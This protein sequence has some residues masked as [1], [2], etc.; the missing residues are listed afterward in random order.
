MD[1]FNSIEMQGG[2]FNEPFKLDFFSNNNQNREKEQKNGRVIL[3][4][5]EN[6][7]GKTSIAEALNNQDTENS[8]YKVNYYLDD[9]KLSNYNIPK[10]NTYVYDEEFI[11]T[12]VKYSEKDQKAKNLKA[13]V[14][15]GEQVDVDKEIDDLSREESELSNNINHEQEK[16]NNLRKEI[17]ETFDLLK[18][19]L[20]IDGG[21]ADLER[22][23]R[24]GAKKASVTKS[25]INEIFSVTQNVK[26]IETLKKEFHTRLSLYKSQKSRNAI[27]IDEI[28]VTLIDYDIF[29]EIR[30][31][32]NKEYK[33]PIR[34]S[35]LKW[36]E[37]QLRVR[38]TVFYEDVIE[39][40]ESK[41]EDQC[42]YCLQK[43][44]LD[45]K[46][47]VLSQLNQLLDDNIKKLNIKI[48]TYIKLLEE[49]M[50]K[51]I[52][53]DKYNAL[54]EKVFLD[55]TK[56][57]DEIELFN[58]ALEIMCEKLKEKKEKPFLE[59]EIDFPELKIDEDVNRINHIVREYNNSLLNIEKTKDELLLLNKQIMIKQFSAQYNAYIKKQDEYVQIEHIIEKL[60]RK[61]EKYI[62]RIKELR[63]KKMN[64]NFA[65][66]IINDY[67]TFIFWDNQ[68]LKLKPSDS[69]GYEVWSK[70]V[71]VELS[72]LSIA[73]RNIISLCY[74]FSKL[75]E[76]K[77]LK[78]KTPKLIVIDDPVSS[79]DSQ[80]RIGIISFIKS[81]IKHLI[82]E[83][84]LNKIILLTHDF[85]TLIQIEK[86]L[87][88]V[89]SELINKEN[90]LIYKLQNKK[91]TIIQTKK[92]NN[93]TELLC[94]S[95]FFSFGE[96]SDNLEINIGNM[97][98]RVVEGYF[99]F[100]YKY[101]V[102]DIFN[103]AEI[104]S[105]IDEE[106]REYYQDKMYR[107]FLHG[108]SHLEDQVRTGIGNEVEIYIS[109]EEKRN[110]SKDILC[111]LY[112]LNDLFIKR[113]LASIN[114]YT[115]NELNN[116]KVLSLIQDHL[117]RISSFIEENKLYKHKI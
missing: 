85:F 102:T 31:L 63:Q 106:R 112:E 96:N 83:N 67:L 81:R 111:F 61:K 99:S 98:R 82:S 59:V 100:N 21:W 11:D 1:K 77:D 38:G 32:L 7:S 113:H 41:N 4:Y 29:E 56:I 22:K 6:G 43:I 55:I 57:N 54:G 47:T 109:L 64:I 2:Y 62:D 28:E 49:N 45:Q 94:I 101:S 12:K 23:I 48:E 58:N 97:L 53:T 27:L 115:N 80:N 18:Y 9:K 15:F 71:H 86:A 93:I 75:K 107:L 116:S 16:L 65:L 42:P 73:E 72:R 26:D 104:V 70:G 103:K 19:N 14:M 46:E 68:R 92:Y 39:V 84:N 114:N 10:K 105:K 25:N 44:D 36:L 66:E 37:E 52:E 51:I 90:Y 20:Q 24:G 117:G 40:M 69:G 33:Q 89:N 8:I 35:T 50:V 78:D 13:V 91:L 79:F 5:G 60:E 76:D 95:A 110:L 34:D 74:F 108:E 30:H 3:I 88:D 87:S 17:D